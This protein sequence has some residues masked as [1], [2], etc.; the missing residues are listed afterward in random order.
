MYETWLCCVL[1][2]ITARFFALSFTCILYIL[3]TA[4]ATLP[5]YV[6]LVFSNVTNNRED[7]VCKRFYDRRCFGAFKFCTN[8]ALFNCFFVCLL[9]SQSVCSLN[10][11]DFCV[12]AKSW[13]AKTNLKWPHSFIIY[14]VTFKCAFD[15]SKYH[16]VNCNCVCI[17]LN[18]LCATP[19]H[20]YQLN[21]CI[22]SFIFVHMR[23]YEVY[24]AWRHMNV[25]SSVFPI[26]CSLYY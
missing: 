4:L 24:S 11:S 26:Q 21:K 15:T 9:I 18:V 2:V 22:H 6:E 12:V 16:K 10:S 3:Y 14:S 7:V 1:C 19:E 23:A 5:G 8:I 13:G 20:V 17:K 25:A